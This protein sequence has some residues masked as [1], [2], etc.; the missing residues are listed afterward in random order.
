MTNNLV[1][2][3]DGVVGWLDKA[4]TPRIGYVVLTTIRNSGGL[5]VVRGLGES[6]AILMQSRFVKMQLN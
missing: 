4:T 1:G 5:G 6:Q 3:D 2:I